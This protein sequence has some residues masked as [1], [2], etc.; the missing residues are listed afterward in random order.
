[1]ALVT[2]E[3]CAAKRDGSVSLGL[4]LVSHSL[5]LLGFSSA[6]MPFLPARVCF[7][8]ACALVATLGGVTGWPG[9]IPPPPRI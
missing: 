9:V 8:V 5:L 2:L 1:M 6:H 3:R 7:C 4:C